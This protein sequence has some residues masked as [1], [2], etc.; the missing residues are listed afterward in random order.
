MRFINKAMDF[1]KNRMSFTKNKKVR[2]IIISVFCFILFAMGS[3]F[4]LGY[5][6][7]NQVTTT[8]ISKTD[9]DLGINFEVIDEEPDMPK[10][11][12]DEDIVNIALLGND[13]R[14]KDEKGRSDAIIIAT[15]DKKHKKIK[16]SSVMR[17]T[18]VNIKGVG[19]DKITHAYF[20][21]GP[22]LTIRTLNENFKMDIRDYVLV[23]FFSLEKIIDTLGGV[24][25]DVKEEELKDLN[26][27]VQEVAD[28]E[29]VS[30]PLFTK[31]GPQLLNGMQAVSYARIRHTGNGDY[32]RTE[33]QRRV[34]SAIFE[35]I[36]TEGPLKYPAIMASLLPY[37]ETSMDKSTMLKLGAQIFAAGMTNLEQQRF[38]LD[39][40]SQGTRINNIWY[41]WADLTATAKHIHTFIY[42]DQTPQVL[43]G[44]KIAKAPKPEPE[45]KPAE[46]EAPKPQQPP[47]APP[48]TPT[49]EPKPEPDPVKPTPDP[50]PNPEPEKPASEPSDKEKPAAPTD[51]N[52]QSGQQAKG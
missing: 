19:K 5:Y 1:I 36:K 38:P 45:P 3:I 51:S 20:F 27:F 46:E 12:M 2:I 48:V 40:A 28:I 43:P 34:L 10:V 42:D 6:Q 29:H 25:M 30:A 49:P 37:T 15:I 13:R 16:L 24:T 21:G 7:L 11:E 22:Q 32:E 14:S 9:E 33:R 26:T 8:N 44:D 41:L 17:D 18:Y 35:K 4:A 52:T 31:S 39:K 23:D 47:V 50:K